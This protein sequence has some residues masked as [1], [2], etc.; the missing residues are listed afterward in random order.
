[1]SRVAGGEVTRS[2]RSLV[3]EHRG[4]AVAAA[5]AVPLAVCALLSIGRDSVTNA[6]AVLVLVLVVVAAA[7]TGDRPTGIAAALS[8]GLWFDFFLTQPYLRFTIA[9]PEDVEATLLLLVIGIAV[10]ELAL[11]GLRQEAHASR[12]AGY[13]E[14]ALRVAR[15]VAAREETPEAVVDL[16]A[17]QLVDVLE[18]S[19]CRFVPARERDARWALLEP[20]GR[21]TR[22]GRP[23]RVERDGLPTDEETALA[24]VHH[25]QEKG[26]FVLTSA[27]EVAR[28]SLEQRRVAVLLADQVG[29]AL[30]GPRA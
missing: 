6:A 13:L 17:R 8:S 12:R 20:D 16:A 19:R 24:V 25:G 10:T 30:S 18:V 21:V 29:V 3:K 14:G 1:M 26:Y 15:V 11:W 7:G 27:S 22:Q 9:D 28:P 5:V 2:V 4:L 23:L